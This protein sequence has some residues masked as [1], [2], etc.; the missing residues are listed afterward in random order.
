[1]TYLFDT[2]AL[3]WW[4]SDPER[5]SFRVLSLIKD[6]KNRFLVSA[7]S[8][9]EVATKFRIGKYSQGSQVVLDWVKRLLEDGYDEI[10][11]GFKHTLKAETYLVFT[12]ILLIG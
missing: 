8:A 6:P 5:L 7:T 10:S 12:A 4:W 2:C 3:L 9:W 1:M 11:F